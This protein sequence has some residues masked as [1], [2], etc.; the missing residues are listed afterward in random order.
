MFEE[1]EKTNIHVKIKEHIKEINRRLPAFKRIGKVVFYDE[2]FEKT[3]LG[4]IR[5]FKYIQENNA[6]A[7]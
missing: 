5:R 1:A 3:A 6:N 2:D 4:K 7:G